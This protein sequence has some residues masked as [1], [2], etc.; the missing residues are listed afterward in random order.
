MSC[1]GV[2]PERHA[3]S[4]RLLRMHYVVYFLVAVPLLF[5]WLFWQ[6][7][8]MPQEPPLFSSGYESAPSKP[9][10]KVAAAPVASPAPKKLAK[11]EGAS[12][13]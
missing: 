11:T 9:P 12:A 13:D 1:L 10:A 8:S 2:R 6:A 4:E 5:G 3:R 7:D